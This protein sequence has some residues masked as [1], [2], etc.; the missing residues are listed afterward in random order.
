MPSV[1]TG[2][3]PSS[4]LRCGTA[5]LRCFATGSF[6]AL[7]YPM[8]IIELTK[9]AARNTAASKTT[10]PAITDE[11]TAAASTQSQDTEMTPSTFSS[12]V[13]AKHATTIT[14]AMT[15]VHLNRTLLSS[16]CA[17]KAP[18]VMLLKSAL[19]I[20]ALPPVLTV[21]ALDPSIQNHIT[22]RLHY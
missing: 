16:S 8:F 5:I 21:Q 17:L 11:I 2:Y 20:S 4:L 10:S 7:S 15:V 14:A 12:D 18:S 1:S 22:D 3:H 19:T 13:V 9:A 6:C